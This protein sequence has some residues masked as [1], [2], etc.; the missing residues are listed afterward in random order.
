MPVDPVP[1]VDRVL[2]G[3]SYLNA[4][5]YVFLTSSTKQVVTVQPYY[6]YTQ[7]ALRCVHHDLG[8][9]TPSFVPVLLL[10]YSLLGFL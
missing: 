6:S 1:F 8:Q 9:E 7:N 10:L 3:L 4:H 2:L 5:K